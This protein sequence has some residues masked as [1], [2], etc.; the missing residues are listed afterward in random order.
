MTKHFVDLDGQIMTV[1]DR[2]TERASLKTDPPFSSTC[3]RR[4]DAM[5]GVTA[6]DL[7]ASKVQ[8]LGKVKSVLEIFGGCGWH[9]MYIQRHLKPERHVVCDISKDCVDSVKAT[10]GDKVQAHLGD[11]RELQLKPKEY[12]WVHADA[13]SYTLRRAM[14]GDKRQLAV[15]NAAFPAAKRFVSITDSAVFGIV[16]FQKNRDS[17]AK[18]LDMDPKDWTDYF[19]VASRV[20]WEQFGFGTSYVVTWSGQACYMLMERGVKCE[21]PEVVLFKERAKMKLLRSED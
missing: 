2:T 6:C 10:F 13:Q 21:E 20:Y 12:D 14:G 11:F 17:Y 9:S 18:L 5:R 16:R 1:I 4:P 19:R 7:L 15:M 8:S 3:W